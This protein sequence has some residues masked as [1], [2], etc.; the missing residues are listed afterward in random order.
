ME[1]LAKSVKRLKR[2]RKNKSAKVIPHNSV[3]CHL[4]CCFVAASSAPFTA[5][6]FKL[7]T[8]KLLFPD[9]PYT[10][11]YVFRP[12]DTSRDRHEFEK[13]KKTHTL[14]RLSPLKML[15][16]LKITISCGTDSKSW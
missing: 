1:K 11:S 16:L 13:E 5:V 14:I 3:F 4:F 6:G 15:F 10:T 2:V 7:V 12:F 8:R 9:S